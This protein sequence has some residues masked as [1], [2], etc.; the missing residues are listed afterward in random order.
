MNDE[1]AFQAYLDDH[2]D[3]HAARLVFADWLQ[4][5][6]DPRAEGYRALGALRRVPND[7][8]VKHEYWVFLWSSETNDSIDDKPYV[9]PSDWYRHLQKFGVMH[10]S[11]YRATGAYELKEKESRRDGEDKAALAFAILSPFRRAELLSSL[12]SVPA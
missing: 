2:P 5:R 11:A 10:G 4:E 3:D 12:T 6:D 9:L 7:T 1:D 8:S